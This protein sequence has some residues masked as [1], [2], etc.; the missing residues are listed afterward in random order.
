MKK[1]TRQLQAYLDELIMSRKSLVCTRGWFP[2]PFFY[3]ICGHPKMKDLPL[4]EWCMNC[5]C[6]KLLDELVGVRIVKPDKT[7]E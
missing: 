5:M 2:L 3:K 1:T 7:D 6:S 4:S